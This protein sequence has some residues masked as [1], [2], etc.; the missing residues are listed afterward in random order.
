[1]PTSQ[2]QLVEPWYNILHRYLATEIYRISLPERG[3]PSHPYSDSRSISIEIITELA[4]TAH[5]VR[6]ILPALKLVAFS[7][8]G[9][10][11]IVNWETKES[12]NI[13]IE[14]VESDEL[15]SGNV[16]CSIR[17]ELRIW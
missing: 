1:V 17:Y 2:I 5:V 10:V 12:V 16:Y 9:V 3:H 14:S 11:D 7:R 8:A 6:A 13:S 4:N 15:V